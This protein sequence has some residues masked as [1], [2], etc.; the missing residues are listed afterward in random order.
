MWD[1]RYATDEFIFGTEP[2]TFLAAMADRIP[3]GRVLSLG[4]G[5]G[6]NAV[7]LAARGCSVVA[8][9]ASSVGLA[10]ARRLAEER[11]V[12][13]ET[14]ATDLA[15][16]PVLPGEWDAIVSIFCH[17]WPGIRANLYRRCVHGLRPGG[18]FVLEA[19][20]PA[21]L[22]HGTGGPPDKDRLMTLATLRSELAGLDFLHAVELEREVQ[23]GRL[24]HGLAAVVQVVATRP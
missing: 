7:F 13:I 3:P 4:E 24:H 5:E 6:R 12:Q 17:P 14:V 9:D 21:Q 16:F 1:K 18:V 11:G 19:Y 23:E 8:V 2:N 10:K 20:T 22:R 15:D